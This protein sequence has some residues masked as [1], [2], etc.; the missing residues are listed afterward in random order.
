MIFFSRVR[1]K[2]RALLAEVNR[3]T[4]YPRDSYDEWKYLR[5]QAERREL[6]QAMRELGLVE[7]GGQ[8]VVSARSF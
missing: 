5:W 4:P 7:K 3:P 1:A 2:W 8:W 6:E